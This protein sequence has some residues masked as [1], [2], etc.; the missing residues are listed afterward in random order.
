[1]QTYS[2]FKP[3]QFDHNIPLDPDRSTWYVV[4][5]G[6][7]R[8]ADCGTESNYHSALR[9]LGGESDTVEVL[10]F[11]H[12]ACGW[13]EVIIV[14]PGTEA[15]NVAEKIESDLED[16][17]ILDDNDFSDREYTVACETWKNCYNDDERIAYIRA[18]KSEFSF[19]SFADML[20]CV[21]GNYFAGSPTELLSN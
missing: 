12:W 5:C 11:G 20:G 9:L 15:Y 8:D 10:R 16:Y 7:N 6:T 21:R 14:K 2:N 13:F 19:G 17:P 3:T 1:M 18:H 4:P